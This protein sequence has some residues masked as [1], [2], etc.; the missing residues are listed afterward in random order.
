MGREVLT[1]DYEEVFIVAAK[2]MAIPKRCRA[3]VRK[4]AKVGRRLQGI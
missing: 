4:T 1:E 2:W 3:P